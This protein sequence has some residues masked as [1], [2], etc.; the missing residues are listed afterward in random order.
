MADYPEAWANEILPLARTLHERVHYQNVRPTLDHER[1]VAAGVVVEQP[2]R[3][4]LS[5]S[6]W[7]AR[8]AL[9]E[10]HKAG[11]RLA[12]LFEKIVR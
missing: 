5:F 4:G 11:W 2:M 7:S 12:D 3:D 6:A 9:K 10:M 1:M 8:S